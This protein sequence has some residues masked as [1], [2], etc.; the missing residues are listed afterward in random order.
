MRIR[1]FTP[2]DQEAAAAVIQAGMRDR[3]GDDYDPTSNPDLRDIGASYMTSGRLFL[4]AEVP[5]GT[6]VDQIVG[7][8]ALVPESP[9]VSRILRI[10]VDRD[11]RRRGTAKAIVAEL[12]AAARRAGSTKVVVSTD[13]PWLEAVALYEATGFIVTGTDDIDTHFALELGKPPDKNFI[14]SADL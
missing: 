5:D 8:G 2:A 4:V 12:L 7:T 1:V 10:S 14:R 9:G 6:V 13:T 3:W 11:W